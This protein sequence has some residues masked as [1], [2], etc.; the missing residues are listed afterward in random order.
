MLRGKWNSPSAVPGL[1]RDLTTKCRL[2]A[3]YTVRA[4]KLF[5]A[6]A[7]DCSL[8]SSGGLLSCS[9]VD[10]ADLPGGTGEVG[11]IHQRRRIPLLGL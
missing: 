6:P 2:F 11:V 9:S 10:F 4:V 3:P 5:L 7:T 1:P 8:P